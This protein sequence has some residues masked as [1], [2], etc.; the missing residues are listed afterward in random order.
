MVKQGLKLVVA[1]AAAFAALPA[2]AHADWQQPVAGS[3]TTVPSAAPDYP[4]IANVG[5]LPTVG[6]SELANSG[7]FVRQLN[8]GAWGFVGGGSA[9]SGFAG[10]FVEIADVGGVPY[11]TY[12]QWSGASINQIRVRRFQGGA[13][14]DVGGSLNQDVNHEA[15]LPRI[16]NVGGVPYVTWFEEDAGGVGQVYVKRFNG[17]TWE[18]P[19]AGSLNIDPVGYGYDSFVASVGGV[20]YVAWSEDGVSDDGRAYV[21]RLEGS[22]WVEPDPGGLNIDPAAETFDATLASIGGVPHVAWLEDAGLSDTTHTYV[23]RLSGGSWTA[24]LGGGALEVDTTED[25]GGLIAS[26]GGQLWVSLNQWNGVNQVGYVRRFNGTS[27]VTV[28]SPLNIDPTDSA[29][30]PQLADVSGTPYVVW[31]EGDPATCDFGFNPSNSCRVYVKR[32][33]TVGPQPAPPTQVKL[34]LTDLKISPKAFRAKS[35]ATIRYRLNRAANVRFTVV[36]KQPGK[37]VNGR[38]RKPTRRN[39]AAKRC[40]RTVVKGSFSDAGTAGANSLPFPGRVGGKR[41]KPGKYTLR[42]L[43]ETVEAT[44]AFRVKKPKKPKR[45]R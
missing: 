2:S 12:Q 10:P 34:Q 16:A 5:G 17:T 21:K 15:S 27:W 9:I 35:G 30:S 32:F 38:C 41:L 29:I 28:G 23:R 8:G 1:V 11:I 18:E 33:V 20:P 24:P 13:W 7:S 3:L 45:R 6:W 26:V 36:Q 31:R 37:R 4:S 14:T 22:S 25:G 44:P 39:R 40:S 42:V 43:A 19:D